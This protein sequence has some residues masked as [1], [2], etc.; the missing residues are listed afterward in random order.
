LLV[1]TKSALLIALGDHRQSSQP[2]FY[3][4]NTERPI[5][6]KDTIFDTF[7]VCW[8]QEYFVPLHLFV[9]IPKIAPIQ[10]YRLQVS[11]LLF[12]L[13]LGRI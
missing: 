5:F 1:W 10:S 6:Q 11:Q 2:S 12:R 9:S 7:R 8:P 13:V 4:G 3:G